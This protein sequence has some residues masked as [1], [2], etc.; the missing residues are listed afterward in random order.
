MSKVKV[1]LH[2]ASNFV[3][4]ALVLHVSAIQKVLN[5]IRNIHLASLVGSLHEGLVPGCIQNL[6]LNLLASQAMQG[7]NHN[8][9]SEVLSTNY[10]GKRTFIGNLN[11][12]GYP[13]R[14]IS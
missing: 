7:A 4:L 8:V 5:N 1:I 10:F 9:E 3:D 13:D 6:S 11:V 12:D 2:L 14:C